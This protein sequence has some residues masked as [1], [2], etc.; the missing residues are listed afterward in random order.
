M[1][2][3]QIRLS[4]GKLLYW[5]L[6][7][8]VFVDF[9][10]GLAP[11]WMI[12][13]IFRI[14]LLLLCVR[15]I[16]RFSRRKTL[17]CCGVI[18]FLLLNS[19]LSALGHNQFSGLIYDLKMALKACSYL[20]ISLALILLYRKGRLRT[21]QIDGI[22]INN[23]LYTPI[24]F[25]VSKVLNIGT[26]SYSS[27]DAGFRAVFLSLNSI[28]T[29][30][31]ALYIF[32]FFRLMLSREK[33][34]WGLATVYVVVPMVLLG[35]KTGLILI[36][37]VPLA[38]L[39]MNIERRRAWKMFLAFLMIALIGLWA[40]WDYISKTLGGILQRQQYLFQNRDLI[41]YFFSGRNWML[42]LAAKEYTR[43]TGL[44][45]WLFGAGY[46]NFHHKLSVLSN[47][48]PADVRPIEMDWADLFTAYGIVGIVITYGHV[49]AILKKSWKFRRYK[50]VQ[51]YL[52]ITV[53]LL[54]FSMFAGHVFTEAISST[55]MAIAVC[56][57]YVAADTQRLN[58]HSLRA[59]API[60]A[61]VCQ[62]RTTRYEI[63]P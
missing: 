47:Y 29:A 6:S 40:A 12:G 33:L 62:S 30:L 39:L 36:V 7:L 54:F 27:A 18:C 31:I 58:N 11:N 17:I 38:F 56:G 35:T 10:N 42:E 44:I 8:T 63:Q 21:E 53:V 19:L 43:S 24:L 46:Y 50:E 3:M 23:L 37:L 34:K 16:T 26:S 41:S 1:R 25:L 22:L 59:P 20:F 13:E 48:G 61:K 9:M 60:E 5:M 28:N 2:K 32:A 49:I 45:E 55:F 14:V 52:L 51:P 15:I 4:A 57:M